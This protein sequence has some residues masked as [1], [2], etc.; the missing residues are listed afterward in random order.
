MVIPRK[1]RKSTPGFLARI[2]A[3]ALGSFCEV[4]E[5]MISS[6]LI[7][8]S[9]ISL[10]NLRLIPRVIQETDDHIMETTGTVDSVTFKWKWNIARRRKSNSE[11]KGYMKKSTLVMKGVNIKLRPKAKENSRNNENVQSASPRSDKSASRDDSLLSISA[12]SICTAFAEEQAAARQEQKG[13][14]KK[15]V[16]NIL[17]QLTLLVEDVNITIE[18]KAKPGDEVTA[19]KKEV[20]IHCQSLGLESLG[21]LSTGKLLK[22]KLKRKERKKLKLKNK[23]LPLMQQLNV[24]S[25]SARVIYINEH[26]VKKVVPMI[27]PFSYSA[28]VKRFHGER[29]SSLGKGVEVIGQEVTS[30]SDPLKI[31]LSATLS[32]D[33]ALDLSEGRDDEYGSGTF[34]FDLRDIEICAEEDG[35][36]ETSLCYNNFSDSVDSTL[37]GTYSDSDKMYS[38]GNNIEE[39]LIDPGI[40]PGIHV[41]LGKYQTVALFGII[42]MFT[43]EK[44]DNLEAKELEHMRRT[45]INSVARKP[46]GLKALAAM[47]P[48]T[49]AKSSM[50]L[51]KSSSYHL[52]FN[53]LYVT[54]PNDTVISASDCCMDM[55]TDGSKSL[56]EVNGG[57]TVNGNDL[58]L[59]DGLL[60]VDLNKHLITIEREPEQLHSPQPL[61]LSNMSQ[62]LHAYSNEE[63]GTAFNFD[64]SEIKDLSVGLGQLMSWRTKLNGR[65]KKG[66]LRPSSSGSSL[67]PNWSLK[68]AGSTTLNF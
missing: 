8:K 52:P 59:K 9:R 35:E 2:V 63:G 46:G 67:P 17:D 11:T 20:K 39:G 26:D 58:L 19:A 7:N 40:G 64:L 14:R 66:R 50:A 43:N 65:S 48:N 60:S 54:L 56:I 62:Q 27:S 3:G 44:P 51:N 24:N 22:G 49:F 68:V 34:S 29:F 28:K 12:D 25:I 4:D 38:F 16:K 1:N 13:F 61:L 45:M 21:R 5:T 32:N 55:R 6:R 23:D 47:A 18:P 36:I 37:S 41:H 42:N 31:A 10:E 57:V 15:F 53:N 30:T 33:E